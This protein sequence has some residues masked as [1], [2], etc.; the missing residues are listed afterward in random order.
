MD[1]SGS[2][3]ETGSHS[4]G[5]DGFAYRPQFLVCK[6]CA[7]SILIFEKSWSVD[8]LTRVLA[9]L[10][11]FIGLIFCLGYIYGA[12]LLYGGT[13]IPISINLTLLYPMYSCPKWTVSSSLKALKRM[14][15]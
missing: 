3:G 11:T 1:F 2:R 4:C 8:A 5:P 13:T 15:Y 9:G 6:R 14:R 12:P 7:F 10:T